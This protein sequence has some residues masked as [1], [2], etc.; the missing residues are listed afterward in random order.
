MKPVIQKCR[1]NALKNDVFGLGP[2]MC[3]VNYNIPRSKYNLL[4]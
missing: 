2:N 4:K 1:K 3:Y